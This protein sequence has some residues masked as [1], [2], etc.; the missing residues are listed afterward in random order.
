MALLQVKLPTIMI[1]LLSRLDAAALGLDSDRRRREASA[2]GRKRQEDRPDCTER[3]EGSPGTPG[4][5]S[6]NWRPA[7]SKLQAVHLGGGGGDA[8]RRES[9]P[10]RLRDDDARLVRGRLSL[11]RSHLFPPHARL[12]R[13][14]ARNATSRRW[15]SGRTRAKALPQRH[16]RARMRCRND[17]QS[18]RWCSAPRRGRAGSREPCYSASVARY[19][20]RYSVGLT[21]A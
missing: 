20:W 17:E 9:Q 19:K 10:S 1:A 8:E 7:E 13:A 2:A 12:T 18:G 21:S 11:P 6:S 5:R 16:W 4:L 14:C 15:P 3:K